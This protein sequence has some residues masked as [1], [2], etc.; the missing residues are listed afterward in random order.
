MLEK[1]VLVAYATRTGSSREIAQE[2]AFR[3]EA[4]G[5]KADARNLGDLHSMVG[6]RAVILGSA[7]REA[8][9]LPEATEFVEQHQAELRNLPVFYFLV[10]LT[11]QQDTPDHAQTA[12]GYLKPIRKWIEPTEV[13]LFAGKFDPEELTRAAE[14]ELHAKGFLEGDWRDWKAVQ[15]W[16]DRVAELLKQEQIARGI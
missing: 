10:S 8:E 9:L 2:I 3:L 11:M 1:P 7:I 15:L 4:K 16:A 5:I 14:E 6:Y 12:L 13:G